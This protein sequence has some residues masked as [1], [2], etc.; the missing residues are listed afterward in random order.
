MA[1]GP[2]SGGGRRLRRPRSG[3]KLL[4]H[5]G[6]GDGAPGL[7]WEGAMGTRGEGGARWHLNQC[8]GKWGKQGPGVARAKG[9][10]E[11]GDPVGKLGQWPRDE[12]GGSGGRHRRICGG[13]AVNVEQGR[14]RAW[15]A[16]ASCADHCGPRLKRLVTF[17]FIQ[18]IQTVLN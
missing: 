17:L 9:R 11:R 3:Q 15:A 18:N 5:E 10:R 7:G 14:C 2:K 1:L 13:H 4:W 12:E 16:M 8:E 6:G